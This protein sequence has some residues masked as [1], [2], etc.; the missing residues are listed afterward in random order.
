M[1]TTLTENTYDSF[2]ASGG[3]K[4]SILTEWFWHKR[5]MVKR[6]KLRKGCSMLE[7]ACGTGFHTDLFCRMGF[8]CIGLDSCE[9]AIEI[10]KKSYPKRIFHECDVRKELPLNEASLDVVVTRGCSLYHYDLAASATIETTAHLMKYLVPG[11][12]FILMIVSDLSGS[13]EPGRVWQNKL[14]D[15]HAHFD[16]FGGDC[17]VNWHKGMVIASTTRAA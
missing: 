15:Y 1:S 11:G 16:H 7:V 8:N 5:H 12:R 2:Y 9:T 3:W 14:S 10:A 6:F 13:R 17:T 4:Y